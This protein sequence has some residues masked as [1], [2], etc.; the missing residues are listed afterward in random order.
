VEQG[1]LH[2]NGSYV[3]LAWR[4]RGEA[5]SYDEETGSLGRVR[6]GKHRAA[7]ELGVR[8]THVDLS[9]GSVDGGAFGRW[10]VGVTWYGP[11]NL[12]AQVDYG[13]AAL[14]KGGI[15]GHTQLLT[16]RFQWE[17]R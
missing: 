1:A 15:V 10:S 4:P 9:D 17:L 5:R 2:F 14:H 8:Y 6:L 13:S 11:H 12:K 3:E 7:V 16:T